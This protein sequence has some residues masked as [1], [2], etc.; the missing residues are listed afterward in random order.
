[1]E[2]KS[3][4]HPP[5][6]IIEALLVLVLVNLTAFMFRKFGSGFY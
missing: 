5:W 6:G 1:M 2:Q 4:I 3:P